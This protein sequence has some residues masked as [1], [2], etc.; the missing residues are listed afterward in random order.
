MLQ[1]SRYGVIAVSEGTPF[2]LACGCSMPERITVVSIAGPIA[3]LHD[4]AVRAG[5]KGSV[6]MLA[7]L[8]SSA[9]WLLRLSL[10]AMMLDLRGRGPRAVEA[11]AWM[12]TRADRPVFQDAASLRLR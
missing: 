4:P 12:F 6:R 9:P 1:L 10:V 3:A 7:T 11:S 5:L 8:A 2:A